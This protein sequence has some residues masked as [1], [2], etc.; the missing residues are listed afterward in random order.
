MICG[1]IF[2]WFARA[3]EMQNRWK[4]DE[5]EIVCFAWVPVSIS[6]SFYLKNQCF[7]GFLRYFCE[8]SVCRSPKVGE[9]MP[10]SWQWQCGDSW[11]PV[12]F[13]KQHMCMS[14]GLSLNIFLQLSHGRYSSQ[15]HAISRSSIARPREMHHMRLN[16]LAQSFWLNCIF[17]M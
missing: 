2:R 4:L 1:V 8:N 3:P 9:H 7:Y 17:L 6:C 16:L 12:R 13:I 5:I 11:M 15:L 10:T 14:L